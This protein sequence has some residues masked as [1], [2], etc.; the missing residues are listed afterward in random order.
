MN[1]IVELAKQ[2][3]EKIK[4]YNDSLP[5]KRWE[6]PDGYIHSVSVDTTDIRLHAKIEIDTDDITE[7]DNGMSVLSKEI[8]GVIYMT[9]KKS[10]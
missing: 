6:L 8:D 4:A 7:L 3:A 9:T 1:E 2:L 10:R 5:R